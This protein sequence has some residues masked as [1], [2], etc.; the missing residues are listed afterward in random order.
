MGQ[1]L[2]NVEA[3]EANRVEGLSALADQARARRLKAGQWLTFAGR[4]GLRLNGGATKSFSYRYKSPIDGRVRQIKIGRWP[5]ISWERA[6]ARWED[7]AK[8]RDDGADPQLDRRAR[9]AEA[10]EKHAADRA[11][12]KRQSVTVEKLVRTFLAEYIEREC[13][14]EKAKYDALRMFES[15]VLPEM[16]ESPAVAIDREDAK[17]FLAR[18]KLEAPAIA[19]LLRSRLGLAWEH[20]LDRK[21]LPKDHANPWRGILTGKLKSKSRSRFLD[22][23][24][25]AT[26]LTKLGAIADAD[27]RDAL[28]IALYTAARSGEVV[29]MDWSA[30]D[31]KRRTWTL[32]ETKSDAPRTIRLPQQAVEILER[33][34]K[35]FDGLPQQAL[36]AALREAGHFG[37]RAFVPHDLR[38]SART[39]MAR[40]RI[41][42]KQP[43]GRIVEERIA[44]EVC[45]A[46]LG[47]TEGG[48][49]GVYNLHKYEPE[50]GEALQA[51]CDHL[52]ALA[53]PE[54]APMVSKSRRRSG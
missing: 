22:D 13:R 34:G 47:H 41:P 54:V 28:L 43:D 18:V 40:I 30:V 25:L 6:V 9:R 46:A 17:D 26:F 48:I 33:R 3:E 10:R 2:R 11:A 27:V 51:W 15:R 5:A 45:E 50:V 23:A 12:A 36:A 31:L 35:A 32:H 29:G 24:E 39:G 44:Q 53:S 52:D 38:R 4:P 49:K 14:T 20:A 37:L 42:R 8:L 16:G 19:R 21:L 1:S 7:L